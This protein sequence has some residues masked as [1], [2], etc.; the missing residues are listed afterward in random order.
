MDDLGEF[1]GADVSLVHHRSGAAHAAA[2]A[3]GI[4]KR[5]ADIRV[6]DGLVLELGCGSGPLTAELIAAGHRVIATDASA[7]MVAL[8]RERRDDGAAELYQLILPD[9]PLPD[10]DAIVAAGHPLNY[11][12][13][14]E[15]IEHASIAI[16]RALRPDGVLAVD[17]CDLEWGRLREHLAP[18]GRAGDDW[19]IITQL[20]APAADRFDRDITVFLSNH[21]GS[22]RRA[23]ERHQSVLID[24]THLPD[25]FAAHGVDATVRRSFGDEVLPAGLRAVTG[26]R[27]SAKSSTDRWWNATTTSRRR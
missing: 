21:D 2:C 24:T 22:W 18:L 14:A 3:P 7:A 6:R 17:V 9:D 27:R 5:L 26:R 13:S 11:L 23:R 25:L 10:A 8:A 1:Y 4:I 19:A 16:A 15:Q 20:S 12:A